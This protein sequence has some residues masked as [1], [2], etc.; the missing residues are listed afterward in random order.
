MA[1]TIMPVFGRYPQ[2]GV[3]IGRLLA[4]YA[5][6][7][8]ELCFCVAFARN[9]LDMIF[10]SMFRSRGETQRVDIAD[11]MGHQEYRALRLGTHFEEAIGGMRYCLKIRN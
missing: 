9:D 7:E 5:D 6:L 1:T 8:L 11:A 2:E 4:G 10:K 3:I